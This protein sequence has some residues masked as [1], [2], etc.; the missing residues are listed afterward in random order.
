MTIVIRAAFAL[1]LGILCLVAAPVM[2]KN[3]PLVTAGKFVKIYDPSVGEQEKWYINDHCFIRGANGMWHLYGITHAEPANPLDEDNFAHA[4]A[5]S[6]TQSPWDKKPFALSVDWQVWNERH[7][8]APHIVFHKG[9]YYMFY[10][11]GDKDSTKY[12]IHLATSR[13]LWVWKRH[14]KN[15]MVVDGF[16]ARDPFVLRVGDQWVMYYTATSDPSGG[17]HIVACR[18][19]KDLITWGERK[20]VFTFPEKGTFGG[21][22]ESPF[23]VRR[24][25][26]YYL[27]CGPRDGYRGTA[28][29]R[30]KDPFHWNKDDEAGLIKSHAAE[31]IQDTDGKW[32]ISHCGWGQGGVYLAP[33]YWRD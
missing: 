17:Y 26:Y 32:Y 3:E 13:D 18:T 19:S 20:V 5:M 14:P 28:V 27:F 1:Q 10:C 25:E 16:D 12:K 11:A 23:V 6:L 21:P 31:V 2:S 24:G 30:S 15:P 8:W 22:T 33:L 4:I 9:I 29:Y 7:L